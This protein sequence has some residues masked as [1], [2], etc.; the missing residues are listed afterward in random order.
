[1][2]KTGSEK[3]DIKREVISQRQQH[4]RHKITQEMHIKEHIFDGID[5]IV[6]AELK[7]IIGQEED[8]NPHATREQDDPQEPP[9]FKGKVLEKVLESFPVKKRQKFP[10]TIACPNLSLGRSSKQLS[11]ITCKPHKSTTKDCTLAS[12]AYKTKDKLIKCNKEKPVQ[13]LCVFRDTWRSS[14]DTLTTV[15][16]DLSPCGVNPVHVIPIDNDFGILSSMEKWLEFTTVETLERYLPGFVAKKSIF[17]LQFCFLRCRKPE[18]QVYIKQV[19]SFPPILS[20]TTKPYNDKLINFNFINLKS[21]SR[22]HFYRSLPKTVQTM[23]RTVQHAKD[24]TVLDFELLQSTTP[25]S[26]HSIKG[27]LSGKSGLDHETKQD[28]GISSFFGLLKSKG[29]YTLLQDDSCWYDEWGSIFTNHAYQNKTPNSLLEFAQ[30]W[31]YYNDVVRSANIDNM[32]LSNTACDV[33]KQY[34]STNQL[35]EPTVCFSVRPYGEFFLNYTTRLLAASRNANTKSPIFAFTNLGVGDE[36]SGTRLRQMDDSFSH[37]VRTLSK[38]QDTLTVIFSDHGPKSTQHSFHSMEGRAEMYDAL[39]FVILPKNVAEKLQYHKTNSLLANQQRLVTTIDIH[40]AVLSVVD[41]T[42][43]RTMGLFSEVSSQRDCGDL[44]MKPSA[45]CKCEDWYQ[46]FPDNHVPFTWMAELGLGE[47][48]NAIQE[49]FQSGNND[50]GF[51]KCQRL[52][53]HSFRK[54]RYRREG[55]RQLVTMDIFVKPYMEIF[56]V[57]IKSPVKPRGNTRDNIEVSA[58]RRVSTFDVYKECKDEEVPLDL[59]ICKTDRYQR[60]WR[61][62]EVSSKKDMIQLIRQ[63]KSFNSKVSVKRLHGNCLLQLL[64][65]HDDRTEVY[66]ITNICADRIYH[67]RVAGRSKSRSITSRNLPLSKVVQPFTMH[68]L[69]SVYHLEKP[70]GF[71]VKMSY[72]WTSANDE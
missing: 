26:F 45:V 51:G 7:S 11:N 55:A 50:A 32:G 2:T 35:K 62:I 22:A 49:E 42:K 37:Y 70:Y 16:C 21:V 48:N 52:V 33:Y 9:P 31:D 61:W 60:S 18:S 6:E 65:K 8:A 43:K 19:L 46:T 34:K 4:I 54:I 23:Q 38:N 36:L 29:Y 1:M 58:L 27:F 5:K 28:Y 63:S 68:F 25:Y 20:N 64:R 72:K 3:R 59:C 14:H 57:Q 13:D 47:I 67:V 24:A 40:N 17:G 44:V 53:G 10:K 12:K 69:F 66:E 39:L 15:H 30:Q 71:Y 56:E 41:P